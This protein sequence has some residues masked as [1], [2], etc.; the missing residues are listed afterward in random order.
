MSTAIAMLAVGLVSYVFR[1]VPLLTV[2]LL[3]PGPGVLRTIRHGGAAAVTALFVTSLGGGAHGS[4]DP[5]L[6]I[7]AGVSLWV[8]VRGAAML[9]IVL[10]GAVAYALVAVTLW[11]VLVGSS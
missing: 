5:A 3:R 6:I 11:R 4:L 9:R 2:G 10:F 7:A 1:V 8:A